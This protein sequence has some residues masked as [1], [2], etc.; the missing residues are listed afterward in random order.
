MLISIASYRN[1]YHV[2]LQ[3]QQAISL[4]DEDQAACLYIDISSKYRTKELTE[5]LVSE[6]YHE[7]AVEIEWRSRLVDHA[8]TLVSLGVE[9][10]VEGLDSLVEELLTMA[11]MV[12]ECCVGAELTFAQLS[13]M[14]DYD[15]L[16]MMMAQSSHEM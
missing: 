11:M 6:W 13:D 2:Y 15:R 12:Y 9:R 8:I 3:V 4:G 5:A 7:R 1:N 14:A 10:G 16:E